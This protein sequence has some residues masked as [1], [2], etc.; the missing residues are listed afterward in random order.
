MSG[1]NWKLKYEQIKLKLM[2]SM[3]VAFRLGYE[4]GQKDAQ[5]EMMAEQQAAAEEAAQQE[6]NAEANGFGGD[7][8]ESEETDGDGQGDAPPGQPG[9][10]GAGD[11]EEGGEQP[12]IGGSG[13]PGMEGEGTAQGELDASDA[14]PDAPPVEG[15]ELDSH[16][17]QLEQLMMGKS[18]VSVEDIKKS[19]VAVKALRQAQELHKSMK[20]IK[21]IGKS[22]KKSKKVAFKSRKPAFSKPAAPSKQAQANLKDKDKAALGV[23]QKIVDDIMKSWEEQDAKTAAKI[24]NI[25]AVE[26]L[27]KKE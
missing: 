26:G 20:A 14:D 24:A 12:E 19:L 5:M 17:G 21:Q 13:K 18:E 27:L 4:Q 11:D 23:Q 9:M 6:A 22:L 16:I 2:S 8:E 25:A 3:D 15:S 1:I 7:G 10:P